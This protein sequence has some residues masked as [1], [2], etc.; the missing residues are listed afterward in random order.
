MLKRD[1]SERR[2]Q[3]GGEPPCVSG[4]DTTAASFTV[5]FHR[6]TLAVRPKESLLGGPWQVVDSL[7]WLV[8][9]QPSCISEVKVKN[10]AETLAMTA[11]S[12]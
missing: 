2:S 8:P 3:G 12:S 4:V 9:Q 10:M 1:L 7:M 11:L 5:L 6:H